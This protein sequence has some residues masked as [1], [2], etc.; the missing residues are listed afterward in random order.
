M[1][2]RSVC[3][4]VSCLPK[5]RVSTDKSKL[6]GKTFNGIQIFSAI[7]LYYR[8]KSVSLFLKILKT[9]DM[10][11]IATSLSLIAI[12]AGMFL[13]AQ[14]KKDNLGNLFKYVSYFVVV[15][16]FLCLVCIS[17]RCMMRGC[18]GGGGMRGDCMRPCPPEQ[19][20]CNEMNE[21]CHK[22]MK[23]NCCIDKQGKHHEEEM[24]EEESTSR[25]DTIDVQDPTTREWTRK[26]I[27]HTS[28]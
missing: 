8:K 15:V 9:I 20:R 13:L 24:E 11:L 7:N 6:S 14:T 25:T 26:I 23:M 19:M 21:E 17:T 22:R 18:Y 2:C 16:G 10:L 12:V 5:R 4:V 3:C 28:K 27:K 1:L